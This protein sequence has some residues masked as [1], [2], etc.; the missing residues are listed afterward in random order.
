[1]DIG[2]RSAEV[3]NI[4]S[5]VI[6][7]YLLVKPQGGAPV[8]QPP[9]HAIDSLPLPFVIL[10]VSVLMASFLNFLALRRKPDSPMEENRIVKRALDKVPVGDP[11]PVAPSDVP[12]GFGGMMTLP[13]GRSVISC[14]MEELATEYRNYTKDQ[15]NR[16]LAGRWVKV[17]G[18]IRD[19]H[20]DGDVWLKWV[21]GVA[22]KLEFGQGWSESLSTLRRGGTVTFRGKIA[23]ASVGEYIIIGK[24]ELL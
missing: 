5:G 3:A 7:I 23:E 4:V 6:A 17:S 22:T 19:I 10:C 15:F 14:T 13:D 11:V 16:R 24:C 18:E 21:Q 8:S 20:S 1:M 9:S 2:K 12:L